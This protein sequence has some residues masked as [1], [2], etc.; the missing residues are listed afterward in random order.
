[1]GAADCG[2]CVGNRVSVYVGAGATPGLTRGPQAHFAWSA[3]L[4]GGALQ[5]S[6]KSARPV[7]AT[8]TSGYPKASD[9]LLKSR[10]GGERRQTSHRGLVA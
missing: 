8:G 10:T 5:A 4:S 2:G 1:M 7:R 6:G 9:W 3:V